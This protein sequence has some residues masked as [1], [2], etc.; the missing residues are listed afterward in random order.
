LSNM[1][2]KEVTIDATGKAIGRVA[3][4]AAVALRN[5]NSAE[6]E[7]HLTPAVKVSIINASLMDVSNKKKKTK[8]YHHYSGY[9]GGLK[10]ETLEHVIDKKGYRE[11]LLRAIKGMLPDNKLRAVAMK[12]LTITE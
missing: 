2:N 1:K 3:S 11:A 7:R 6:F 4:E 12:N 5:K 9:P 8:V 10:E